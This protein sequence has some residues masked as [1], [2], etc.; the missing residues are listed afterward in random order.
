MIEKDFKIDFENK[1][2]SCKERGSVYTI[3]ELYSLIMD[4]SDEPKNM[5]YDIPIEAVGKGKFKLINGWTINE[6]A[7]K[8]LKGDLR[9]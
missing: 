1:K 8:H 5:K 7:K 4:L 6:K 9:G 2:I 3:N